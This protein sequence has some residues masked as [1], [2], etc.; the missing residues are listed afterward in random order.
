MFIVQEAPA[1]RTLRHMSTTFTTRRWRLGDVPFL[2]DMLYESIHVRQNDAP[3]PRSILAEHDIAH[4]LEGF[5][6]ERDDAQVALDAAGAWIGAA[7]C[8]TTTAADPGYGFVADDI[9][10]LGTAVV[11]AWRGRGVG[12]RLIEELA[13][14][15]PVLSLSVDND[16]EHAQR[17]YSR[18]G[19]VPL[20]VN[21][22][23]TTMLRRPRP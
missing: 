23:A 12:S 7:W 16:N 20:G 11:A 8:R 4:Y 3:P 21:G 1:S 22:T 9:P 17:L 13:A 6:R 15:N 2:W 14:R 19:F 5:G 18:L 10:E